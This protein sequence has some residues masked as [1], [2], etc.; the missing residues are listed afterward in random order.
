M[1]ASSCSLGNPEEGPALNLI[2]SLDKGTLPSGETLTITVTAQNVGY[3]ALTLTGPTNCLTYI[4]V[5]NTQGSVVWNSSAGCG[6]GTVTQEITPGEGYTETVT[7]DGSNLAGAR[8]SPG[9]Y[10]I[11]PVARLTGAPYAGPTVT[12]AL[13]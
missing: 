12:V 3:E 5:F 9:F 4:E 7:W 2:V 1:L 8:L 10:V 11:R 13:E 6:P